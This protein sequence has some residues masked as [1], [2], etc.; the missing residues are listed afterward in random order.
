MTKKE[1]IKKLTETRILST[2]L[3]KVLGISFET[4]LK[5]TQLNR[6]QQEESINNLIIKL[7]K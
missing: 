6:H 2:D 4:F 3:L 1:A 5:F 7:N